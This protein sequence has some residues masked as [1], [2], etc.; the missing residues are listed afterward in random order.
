MNQ[1]IL[2]SFADQMHHWKGLLMVEG[3][4][5]VTG[6]ICALLMKWR[7]LG[8]WFSMLM[9]IIGAYLYTSFFMSYYTFSKK[10]INNE[11]ICAFIGA[12]VLTVI[13]NLIF[14][15]NRGKDRTFWRA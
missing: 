12:F 9:G 10:H 5:L 3:V 2:F 15:S 11:I 7:S 8:V 14:G 1:L 6:L 4:G 13:I